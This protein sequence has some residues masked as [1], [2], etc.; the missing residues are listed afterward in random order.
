VTTT[1]SGAG[2]LQVTIAAATDAGSPPNRL[3]SLQFGAATNALIDVPGQPAG[4][5]GNFTVTLPGIQQQLT[6]VVR[7]A[8]AGQSTTVPLTVQDGCGAW[9]TFVGGGPSAF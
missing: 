7:R 3:V 2:R 8:A 6:F 5:T 1:P 9:P 4:Q